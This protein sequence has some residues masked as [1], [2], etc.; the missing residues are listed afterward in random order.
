[1]LHGNMNNYQKA[2]LVCLS[3]IVIAWTLLRIPSDDGLRH[4]GLAF[5]DLKSWGD[6]YPFSRFEEF[7]DY[8]PWYGYDRSLHWA[9]TPFKILP[10]PELVSKFILIKI[11]SMIFPALLLCLAL[12]RSGLM[13]RINDKKTSALVLMVMLF[14]LGYAFQ[15]SAIARPFI[16]GT[17][18]LLYSIG[19][20]GFIKGV[21]SSALLTFFYPYL[22]VLYPPCFLCP[23]AVG[24]QEIF[25]G[26]HILSHTF[27]APSVRFILGVSGRPLSVGHNQ[28]GAYRG[29]WSDDYN[30]YFFYCY[31]LVRDA[32]PGVLRQGQET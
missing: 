23:Y 3:V 2:F 22:M 28:V 4:I 6:V 13:A 26:R 16:F 18:F 17:L 11:L 24:R 7:K 9:A 31:G 20:R 5:G 27:P 14:F 32:V 29:I 19:R 1:M 30:R 12:K 25:P 21:V 10:I 15:R 8:D